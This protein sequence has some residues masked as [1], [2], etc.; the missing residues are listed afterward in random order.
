MNVI[1]GSIIQPDDVERV[2]SPIC[3]PYKC[4]A[5]LHIASGIIQLITQG[6]VTFHRSYPIR[7]SMRIWRL[8][9]LKVLRMSDFLLILTFSK[10]AR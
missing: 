6:I 2:S 3:L 5:T 7:K 8:L 10:V 1:C 4:Y 9:R